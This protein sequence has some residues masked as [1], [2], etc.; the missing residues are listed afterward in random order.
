MRA[1]KNVT[2][3]TN[4]MNIMMVQ[5]SSKI[6]KEPMQCFSLTVIWITNIGLVRALT[7]AL[8]A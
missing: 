3:V 2:D 4:S 8:I 6:Q 7:S 5:K 1:K